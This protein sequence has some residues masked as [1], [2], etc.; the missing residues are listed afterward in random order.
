MRNFEPAATASG[1]RRR[2]IWNARTTGA[3]S[4]P[5]YSVPVY[6]IPNPGYGSGAGGGKPSGSTAFGMHA[7]TR[8]GYRAASAFAYCTELVIT[9]WA[10]RNTRRSRRGKRARANQVRALE[11]DSRP[12]MRVLAHG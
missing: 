6:A 11:S 10:A 2:N 5:R 9:P 4:R 8:S 12:F 7:M 1:W 3:R